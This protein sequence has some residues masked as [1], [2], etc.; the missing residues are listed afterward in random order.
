MAT[1]SHDSVNENVAQTCADRIPRSLS[2]R[3]IAA[4]HHFSD[5]GLY[6]GSAPCDR[7]KPIR[8]LCAGDHS[9]MFVYAGGPAH[10]CHRM[11]LE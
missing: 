10:L 6:E 7:L 5:G 3:V 1:G 8:S 4:I 2:G 9:R 11:G